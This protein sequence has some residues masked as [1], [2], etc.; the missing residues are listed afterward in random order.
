MGEE[1]LGA[2]GGGGRAERIGRDEGRRSNDRK[3]SAEY[4]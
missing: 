1:G 2:E 3:T 4:A